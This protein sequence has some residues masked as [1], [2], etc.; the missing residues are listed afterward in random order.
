[1]CVWYAAPFHPQCW[2]C[3]LKC[4]LSIAQS[5]PNEGNLGQPGAQEMRPL[6][7]SKLPEPP[8]ELTPVRGSW[9][10][11]LTGLPPVKSCVIGSIPSFA[12]SFQCH[13]H[14]AK[15]SSY[16]NHLNL[17]FDFDPF[18]PSLIWCMF[19]LKFMWFTIP[20]PQKFPRHPAC[21]EP[22][23]PVA[24]P[25]RQVVPAS[26]ARL[27]FG[28]VNIEGVNVEGRRASRKI[29]YVST[30]HRRLSWHGFIISGCLEGLSSSRH[31]SPW[32]W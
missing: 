15:P 4:C 7:T 17:W 28:F 5:D 25:L 21:Q 8:V 11:P 12:L 3:R 31:T 29:S 27:G 9:V 19:H 16:L 30:Y 22:L 2:A 20:G 23:M 14:A 6:D 24:R 10:G 1:M 13:R 32:L 26:S 18:R